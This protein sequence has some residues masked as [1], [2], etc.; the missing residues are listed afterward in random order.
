MGYQRDQCGVYGV[1][2]HPLPNGGYDMRIC[3]VLGISQ[4]SFGAPCSIRLGLIL[5]PMLRWAMQYVRGS[6]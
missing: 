5:L 3:K 1:Y 2:P 4:V 6:L